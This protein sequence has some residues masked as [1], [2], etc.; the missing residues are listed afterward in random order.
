MS[1]GTKIKARVI[2]DLKSFSEY[3]RKNVMASLFLIFI[4]NMPCYIAIMADENFFMLRQSYI[5]VAIGVAALIS[6]TIIN[7]IWKLRLTAIGV[8]FCSSAII[9]LSWDMMGFGLGIAASFGGT[10]H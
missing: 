10:P 1:I 6:I 9:L 8:I 7:R 4:F 3:G 2:H 5:A